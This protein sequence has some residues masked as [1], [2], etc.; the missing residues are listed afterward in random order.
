MLI[1]MIGL[2]FVG[3]VFNILAIVLIVKGLT[4]KE[5]KMGHDFTQG[6]SDDLI[7]AV[8]GLDQFC[9]NWCMNCDETIK[10]DD[11][12]FRCDGCVFRN[13]ENEDC[14][15]KKF[16]SEHHTELKDLGFDLDSFGSMSR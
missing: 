16:I 8:Q 3:A 7:K 14:Y 4:E 10:T 2:W 12:V 11:L 1:L 6:N 5:K 13:P 9:K 15:V